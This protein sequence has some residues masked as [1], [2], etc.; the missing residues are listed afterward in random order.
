MSA[1][2]IRGITWDHSRAYSPL[3]ATAQRFGE[4]H[5]GLSVAWEKR[6][7]HEF[8]HAS[9]TA[10]CS[11]FDLIVVD[12]PMMGEAKA[13]KLL[14][15]LKPFLRP[16]LLDE[17]SADSVGPSFASYVFDGHLYALP[18]DAST[19]AASSRPDLLAA[20]GLSEPSTWQELMT[21]AQQGFVRMPGFPADLFL[22]F[23][24]LCVSLGGWIATSEE[25]LVERNTALEAL[26]LLRNLASYMPDEIYQW[27][28]IVL[29]ER[30][31]ATDEFAYCPFAYT[32][33]NYARVG[34]AKHELSFSSPVSLPDGRRVRTVLGGTGIGISQFCKHF[35]AALAVAKYVQSSIC[36]R[37][38]YTLCG[39]QPARRSAWVDPTLN[40]IAGHFFL[41][42]L[43]AMDRAYVRPRYAGYVSFQEKAGVPIGEYL[44]RHRNGP[45]QH[46]AQQALDTVNA[47][48]RESLWESAHA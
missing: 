35:E 10:L 18:I 7:L 32:Y 1:L 23:M 4:E 44:R 47:L 11:H 26:E 34:F 28:P 8:G 17:M 3:V 12:H 33:S 40:Q 43:P 24:G 30:M 15:D 48:Y 9:L 31:A 5:P 14:L 21:L 22:N 19:P 2:T 37:T 42:T 27:N 20:L 38:M 45:S 41:R 36:Q 13:K 46:S 25:I 16:E 39:G 29:Y 6:S